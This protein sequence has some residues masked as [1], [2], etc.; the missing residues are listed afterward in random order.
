MFSESYVD[1]VAV[2]DGHCAG[3]G[4][5]RRSHHNRRPTRGHDAAAR[6][7]SSRQHEAGIVPRQ[8]R[9]AADDVRRRGDQG[10]AEHS[11]AA[12]H[13]CLHVSSPIFSTADGLVEVGTG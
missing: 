6:H 13:H 5:G 4:S 10:D 9:G 12:E 11:A 8:R 3:S 2:V 1:I 7:V